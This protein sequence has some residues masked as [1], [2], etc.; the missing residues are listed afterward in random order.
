ME[1]IDWSTGRLVTDRNSY[2]VVAIVLY[3]LSWRQLH[4]RAIVNGGGLVSKGER[5]LIFVYG[6]TYSNSPGGSF[7]AGIHL[8]CLGRGK[9]P[10]TYVSSMGRLF[11]CTDNLTSYQCKLM[12]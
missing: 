2:S 6:E 9:R 8:L 3:E 10:S 5:F 1:N 12:F 4:Q 11:R 7:P